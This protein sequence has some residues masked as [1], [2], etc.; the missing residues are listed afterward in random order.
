MGIVGSCNLCLFIRIDNLFGSLHL[1]NSNFPI[2]CYF[3]YI[4]EEPQSELP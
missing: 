1:R 2:F 3:N 4:Q